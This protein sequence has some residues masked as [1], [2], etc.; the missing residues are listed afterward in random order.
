[1]LH[2]DDRSDNTLTRRNSLLRKIIEKIREVENT[3]DVIHLSF[4]F[5][6]SQLNI[7]NYLFQD[8]YT[9]H[10]SNVIHKMVSV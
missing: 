8:V 5:Q 2:F 6:V 10:K 3:S 7:L 4:L 1:M 9:E